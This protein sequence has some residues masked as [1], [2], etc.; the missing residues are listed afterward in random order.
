MAKHDIYKFTSVPAR[1]A[2]HGSR[3]RLW[4]SLGL[5]LLGIEW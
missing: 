1:R 2:N 4:L 5:V 3:K